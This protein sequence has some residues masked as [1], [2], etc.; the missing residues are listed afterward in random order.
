[1]ISKQSRPSPARRSNGLRRTAPVETLP[2]R[3]FRLRIARG[4]SIYELATA[5]G[6]LAYTIRRLESGKSID[7]RV[8]PMLAMALGVPYCRLLWGDHSCVEGGRTILGRPL[9][10]VLKCYNLLGDSRFRDTRPSVQLERMAQGA[11]VSTRLVRRTA[12]AMVDRMQEEWQAVKE[13][14]PPLAAAVIDEQFRWVPLF[15]GS[16]QTPVEEPPAP[17]PQR[18]EV[19]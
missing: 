18:D 4:Y 5:A 15:S 16:H 6:V 1:M 19:S 14:V 3:I 17:S 13:G 2:A 8:L 11:T 7:K 12:L 9:Q 10:A